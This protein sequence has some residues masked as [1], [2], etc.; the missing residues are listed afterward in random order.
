MVTG[1]LILP[2]ETSGW[3]MP[4]STTDSVHLHLWGDANL[5]GTVDGQDFLAWNAAKFSTSLA[6]SAGNFNGDAVVDG[7][8]FLAWN[9]HKFLGSD[10]ASMPVPESSHGLMLL[11]MAAALTW[12]R[13]CA[14]N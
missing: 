9:A 2:I 7:A 14:E 4:R 10:A 1:K 13:R 3:P 6:W 12:R 8:D 11:L 5:D